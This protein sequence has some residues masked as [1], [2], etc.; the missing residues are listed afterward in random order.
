[1]TDAQRTRTNK[2]ANNQP[3]LQVGMY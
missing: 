2:R 3:T 1:M